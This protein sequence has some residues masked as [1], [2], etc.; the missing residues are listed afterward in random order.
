MSLGQAIATVVG[1]FLFPFIIRMLWGKMVEQWGPIGGWMAAAF[2]VGTVWSA[3]HG[4]TK[5]L[6]YQSGDAWIDMALAAGV[7]VFVASAMRGGNVPKSVPNIIA[8]IIGGT[9]GGIILSFVL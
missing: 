6:I 3:N 9:L 8:A 1:G 2:I 5:P 4:M 7:G